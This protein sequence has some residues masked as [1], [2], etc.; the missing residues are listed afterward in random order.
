[1]EL[2]SNEFVTPPPKLT[3]LLRQLVQTGGSDLHLTPQ[4]R[5]RFR[6]NGEL[7]P[8][9]DYEH[10]TAEVTK[11]YAYNY[12]ILSPAKKQLLEEHLQVDASTSLKGLSRFRINVCDT[13]A[14]L[15]LTFR[16]IP[17]EPFSFDQLGVPENMAE[18]ASK[19][20]GLVL[21]TGPTGSGKSTTLAAFIDKINRERD[22]KIITIED[23]IEFL[24]PSKRCLVQ[25]RELQTNTRSFA[26][27]TTNALRENPDIVLIGELRDL[28]TIQEALRVAETGHLTFATLHSNNA[29]STIT[30]MIDVFPAMQQPQIRTQLADVLVGVMS[31]HLLKR[32][33]DSGRVMALETMIPTPA[34]KNL[35]RE[36]KIHQIKSSMA[37][38]QDK[39]QM[40]TMNQ[41][42]ARLVATGVVNRDEA[43]RR[44]PDLEDF[45]SLVGVYQPTERTRIQRPSLLAERRVS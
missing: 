17:F 8:L 16:A 4:N 15:A 5:P 33:D 13:R 20:Y 34:I 32:K 37:T 31:Q 18:L 19:P 3:E 24:H 29:A 25:Q 21:V 26:E 40:V 27:A 45:K 36:N 1:M 30:R 28:A 14:G 43:E 12:N 39:H 7:T 23:P 11:D 6:V 22:Q 44:S 41:S 35:I 42:L 2:V 38:G 10:L 9:E